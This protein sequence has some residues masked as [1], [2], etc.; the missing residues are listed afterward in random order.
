MKLSRSLRLSI[1][2][3]AAHKLRTALSMAGL[4][5]GVAAVMIMVAIGRGAER[6]VLEQ[7]QAMGTDLVVV[8]AAPAPRVAGRERQAETYTTLRLS[9]AEL[10]ARESAFARAAAPGVSRPVTVRRDG[11]TTGTTL[12]G[13]TEEG[14]RIRSIETAMGRPFDAFEDLERRRVVV[15]GARVAETLF[16]AGDPIG[17]EVRIG[18]VPFDVIG[19]ART[20]GTDPGG[21]DLDDI[22]FVPLETAMRRVLN[23]PYV[24]HLYV[25][26]RSTAD[27]DALERDT[28]EILRQRHRLRPGAPEP[29]LVQNQAVVLRIAGEA[30]RHLTLLTASVAGMALAVGG[31]GIVAVMLVSVRERTREIGLRRAVGARRR[32]IH[33]QVVLET[34]LLAAVGGTAGIAI[35]LLAAQLAA[36]IGPWSVILPVRVAAFGAAASIAIGLVA[37]IAPAR[38]A[39]RLEP[40]RALRAE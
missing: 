30:A 39:A 10:I 28:R 33:R 29:F 24:H 13:T 1:R 25:Q 34:T 2:L 12:V 20:R 18:R 37:G 9:D 26:A 35:G 31:I 3:L 6:R 19:V 22:V 8:S 15:L 4:V 16:A 17:L 36:W 32:D 27:L 38:R 23:I 5:V 40:I 14:L 11:I 7:I 21:A